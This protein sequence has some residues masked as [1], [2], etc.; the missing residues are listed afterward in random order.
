[1][2]AKPESP[3][4]FSQQGSQNHGRLGD[5]PQTT[6][7]TQGE[8]S[9]KLWEAVGGQTVVTQIILCKTEVNILSSHISAADQCSTIYPLSMR[10]E[11]CQTLR[12]SSTR[13]I[14]TKTNRNKQLRGNRLWK[15][16]KKKR[17]EKETIIN[18][19]KERRENIEYL[20][21]Q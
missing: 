4:P 17:K 10:M 15:E 16:Q 1:M 6:Q 5:F 14:V 8:R 11:N 2:N 7:L 12:G 20:K 13:S 19:L 18:A 3:N 9:E 21:L